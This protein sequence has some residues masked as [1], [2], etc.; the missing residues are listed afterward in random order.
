MSMALL[1]CKTLNY[2]ENLVVTD[3]LTALFSGNIDLMK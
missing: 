3:V 1:L 2:R